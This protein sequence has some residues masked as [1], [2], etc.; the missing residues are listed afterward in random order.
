[1][2]RGTYLHLESGVT[3]TFHCA[4]G[5]GGWRYVASRDDGLAVDLAVDSR[6]LP[7][8]LELRTRDWLVRGGR[9]GPEL[10]FL[11]SP[12]GAAPLAVAEQTTERS[13][14]ATGF[15]A[16]SPGLLVAAARCLGLTVGAEATVRLVAV[17]G[18]A[19]AVRTLDQ[20]WTLTETSTYETETRPLPVEHYEIAALDTGQLDHLHLAGDVVLAT[21]GIELAAL[22]SPPTLATP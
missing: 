3:E 6:W 5:P 21:T 9:T 1:V 10:L 11:R 14:R 2:P 16:D 20:R 19:L 12:A 4:P 22:E 7:V 8:R 17:T 15:L 18:P 13:V